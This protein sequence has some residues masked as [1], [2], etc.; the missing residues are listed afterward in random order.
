[1]SILQRFWSWWQQFLNRVQSSQQDPQILILE[2]ILTPSSA[3][4]LPIIGDICCDRPFYNERENNFLDNYPIPD[5]EI[6]EIVS[7]FIA[8]FF[9]VGETGIVEIEFL[10]DGWN[11]RGEVAIFSLQGMEA[12]MSDFAAFTREAVRRSISQS[13]W[14][15]ALT[16]DRLSLS[17]LKMQPSDRFALL[18]VPEGRV[19]ELLADPQQA[20][21]H[22]FFSLATDNID[23]EF[24]FGQTIDLIGNGETFSVTDFRLDGALE[25]DLLFAVRG[26][27]GQAPTI[28]ELV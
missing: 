16:R 15:Y 25:G 26:A 1:M 6:E 14:G 19:A 7:E 27:T 17:S 18:F 2:P 11:Y 13:Q 3:F 12:F 5:I 23:D 9:T 22:Q 21:Q 28:E 24:Y 10:F 8:G 20:N 4:A